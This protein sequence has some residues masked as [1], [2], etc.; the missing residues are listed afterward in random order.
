M[1]FHSYLDWIAENPRSNDFYMVANNHFLERWGQAL[2]P[3][4]PTEYTTEY[5]STAVFLWLGSA[6]T[7]TP[8]HFDPPDILVLPALRRKRGLCMPQKSARSFIRSGCAR[9]V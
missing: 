9:V 6:G 3:E 1:P 2:V 5:N 4:L 7:V 8:L